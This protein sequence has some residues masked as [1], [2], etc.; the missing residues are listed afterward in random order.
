M[1][2]F[3]STVL[4]YDIHGSQVKV[5]PVPILL[6]RAPTVNDQAEEGSVLINTVTDLAY[7]CTDNAL[8]AAV[9]RELSQG[10]GGPGN[11]STLTATGATNL[12]VA[13]A[14]VFNLL[15]GASTGDVHINDGT[16]AGTIGIGNTAA[17]AL[18][19]ASGAAA[20]LQSALSADDAV[21]IHASGAAGEVVIR[22]GTG[23]VSIAEDAD[24]TLVS[25]ADVVPSAAR[26]VTVSGGTVGSAIADTVD[27]A[28][29]GVN[30]AGSSKVV[31]IASGA[32]VDGTSQVDI[33]I[34]DVT[35]GQINQVNIATGTGT[36]DVNIGSTATDTVDLKGVVNI[37][38]SINAVTTINGGTSTGD[39]IIAGAS[40]GLVDIANIT[41][42]VNRTVAIASGTM[43]TGAP[44]SD[45]LA[46]ANGDLPA[47]AA[48]DQLSR[49]VNLGVG[50]V[51]A[52]TDGAATADLEVNI[53]TGALS[54]DTT[55]TAT[56]TLNLGTG[57]S[58]DAA[59]IT[60]ISTG[61]RTGA[62]DKEVNIGSTTT[63]V[64]VTGEDVTVTTPAVTAAGTGL[65]I[66]CGAE[67]EI[68]ILAGAGA[69]VNG[70]TLAPQGSIYIN[71]TTGGAS[72]TMYL[73][74]AAN[75][76]VAVTSA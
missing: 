16:G 75:T 15:T 70:T 12:N 43:V 6:N 47:S 54:D 23:G 73:A 33:A 20:T 27:I 3:N 62:V 49:T 57:A 7:M 14:N 11:F 10:G 4:S 34:G 29:D 9:W 18:T 52:T 8:G 60:N 17:G 31:T 67:A 64:N 32:V 1:A 53:A 45:V 35:A 26:T 59:H 37:N 39:I 74:S 40:V 50:T 30:F 19:L 46:M 21:I 13:T 51:S 65:G 24:S 5:F 48:T 55:G 56:L 58:T 68:K 38:N 22:S 41:P 2:D 63:V 72:T 44:I 76:W 61:T 69:P 66:V 42:V 28:P 36:S 25:I 71:N